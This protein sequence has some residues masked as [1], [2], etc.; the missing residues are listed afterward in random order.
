M[1][2]IEAGVGFSGQLT[3]KLGSPSLRIWVG[4]VPQLQCLISLFE[5]TISAKIALVEDQI[6]LK[7]KV[8]GDA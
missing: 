1:A 7:I 6:R 4:P 2:G 3:F 5:P 8:P